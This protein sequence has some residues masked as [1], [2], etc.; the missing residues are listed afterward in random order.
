[1]S[2]QSDKGTA[3]SA[4]AAWP[5]RREVLCGCRGAGHSAGA[6]VMSAVHNERTGTQSNLRQIIDELFDVPLGHS[7]VDSI[8]AVSM[9]NGLDSWTQKSPTPECKKGPN[10][11]SRADGFYYFGH[12]ND[13]VLRQPFVCLRVDESPAHVRDSV[14]SRIDSHAVDSKRI[15]IHLHHPREDIVA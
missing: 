8:M 15:H 1:M 3:T 11:I 4:M 9:G 2:Q 7:R 14:S 13:L 10:G 6:R 5:S 12:F